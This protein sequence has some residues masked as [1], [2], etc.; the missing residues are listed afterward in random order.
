M[1]TLQVIKENPEFVIERL[2]VKGFD[3]RAVITE[4]LEIDAERRRLQAK[5]D[6][7]AS[8]LKKLASSI[9]MLMKSGDKEGAEE[10]KRK[11]AEIKGATKGLQ[12]R[13]EECQKKVT[14][15]LLS[16]P[17]LPNENVPHGLTAEENVVEKT[18][19]PSRRC[20]P[21]LG[22]RQEIQSY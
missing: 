14:E 7:D 6:N 11:V 19:G 22:T 21:P 18:G 1:L 3:G 9:A 12:D 13:L 8:E 2:G 4:I 10:A 15:L 17:N 20:S 16:V 5:C